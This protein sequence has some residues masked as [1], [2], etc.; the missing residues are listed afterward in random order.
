MNLSYFS[1]ANTKLA[2]L[3]LNQ[4]LHSLSRNLLVFKCFERYCKFEIWV[5]LRV[6]PQSFNGDYNE[7]ETHK[8]LIKISPEE[9]MWIIE[10]EEGSYFNFVNADTIFSLLSS[11]PNTYRNSCFHGC[12]TLLFVQSDELKPLLWKSVQIE[13]AR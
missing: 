11:S 7:F 3:K 1:M 5:P 4:V 9:W 13:Y 2:V 6:D 8:C 12:P 10:P